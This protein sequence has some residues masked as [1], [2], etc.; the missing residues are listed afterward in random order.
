MDLWLEKKRGDGKLHRNPGINS[1]YCDQWIKLVADQ[2]K[3]ILTNHSFVSLGCLADAKEVYP[4]FP[5]A[6]LKDLQILQLVAVTN[7]FLVVWCEASRLKK[8][9]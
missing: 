5:Q 1:A 9:Q 2:I 8:Q 7:C 6:I 3:I 4:F